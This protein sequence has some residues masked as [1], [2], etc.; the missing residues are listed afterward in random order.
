MITLNFLE[1]DYIEELYS[2]GA[3]K[4]IFS[5]LGNCLRRSYSF[6]KNIIREKGALL[7]RFMFF[8][9]FKIS[10]IKYFGEEVE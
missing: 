3:P 5:T 8:P 4:N 10:C 6:F 7:E 2:R 1:A 9:K